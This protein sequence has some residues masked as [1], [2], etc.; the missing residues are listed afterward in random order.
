MIY[1]DG[2]R[3]VIFCRHCK[4]PVHA[5]YR[6]QHLRECRAHGRRRKLGR[7]AFEKNGRQLYA[8]ATLRYNGTTWVP[9]MQYTHANNPA[10]AR[11]SIRF[12]ESDPSRLVIVDAG[13]AIGM[14]A[15]DEAGTQ[16]VAD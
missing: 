3:Q 11:N 12:S 10:H 6:R 7:M 14:F 5:L 4:Q 15:L 8:V 13:L 1:L 9:Q 16:L 2:G